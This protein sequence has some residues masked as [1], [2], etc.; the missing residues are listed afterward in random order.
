[1]GNKKTSLLKPD[2]IVKSLGTIDLH[3]LWRTGYK[4][5]VLDLDNTITKWHD[6]SISREALDF[7]DAAK[8]TGY[9]ICLVS[10]AAEKRTKVVA[11]ELGIGFVAPA[12]KP[13]KKGYTKA[14]REFN[15]Q[16]YQIIA[17]GD[18]IFTDILGGNL[19]GFYTILV[20]PIS[21]VEFLGTKIFRLMEF[22]TGYRRKN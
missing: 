14:L 13:L 3:D 18:Q 17:V 6:N 2:Q 20:P 10:N 5:V 11:A 21:N 12:L 7:V 8:E 4:G 16:A 15:L 9:K 1:M 22:V 19:M